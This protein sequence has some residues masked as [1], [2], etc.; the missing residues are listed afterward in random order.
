MHFLCDRSFKVTHSHVRQLIFCDSWQGV[1]L[2]FGGGNERQRAAFEA[3]EPRLYMS[4]GNYIDR[5]N[6]G[7]TTGDAVSESV[8]H[9]DPGIAAAQLPVTGIGAEGQ[10]FRQLYAP[11]ARP[12]PP[13]CTVPVINSHLLTG[14][15]TEPQPRQRP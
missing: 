3:L 5:I 12:L 11:P 8:H 6:F 1:R 9:F 4:G 2:C 7:D 10:T 14:P 13:S 15:R